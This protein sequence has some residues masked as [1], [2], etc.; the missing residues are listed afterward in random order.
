MIELGRFNPRPLMVGFMWAIGILTLAGVVLALVGAV[1][2]FRGK[3]F[4]YPLVGQWLVRYLE[5][6]STT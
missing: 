2:G 6:N 3:D 4:S 1:Q 5:R